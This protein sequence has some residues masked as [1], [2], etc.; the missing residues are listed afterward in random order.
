MI[1]RI[2]WMRIFDCSERDAEVG[3]RNFVVS[4]RRSNILPYN[5]YDLARNHSWS[6]EQT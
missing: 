1:L 6:E 5:V 2:R 3:L 4:S